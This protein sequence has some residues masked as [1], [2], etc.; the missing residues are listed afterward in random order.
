MIVLLKLGTVLHI[1][2]LRLECGTC[3]AWALAGF[4]HVNK[5]QNKLNKICTDFKN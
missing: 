2:L 5:H 3:S 1:Q 4:L